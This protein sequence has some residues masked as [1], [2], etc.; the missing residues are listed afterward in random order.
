MNDVDERTA[1][2]F[3]HES[4][5]IEARSDDNSGKD[6]YIYRISSRE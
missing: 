1:Y 3:D 6:Y 5:I 2:W 4:V